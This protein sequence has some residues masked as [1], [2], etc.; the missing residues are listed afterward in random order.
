MESFQKSRFE[1]QHPW[2]RELFSSYTVR[3][4]NELRCP[5]VALMTSCETR[6]G[7]GPRVFLSN[8]P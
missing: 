4:D 5:L 2:W 8:W 3:C 7:A 1:T 6:M